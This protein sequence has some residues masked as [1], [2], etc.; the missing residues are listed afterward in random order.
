MALSCKM[1]IHKWDACRCSKCLTKRD[2]A[3]DWNGCKCRVCDAERDAEHDWNGCT[4]LIC[5]TVRSTGHKN[6]CQCGI[7]GKDLHTWTYA[8]ECPE[9][10]IALSAREI[11]DDIERRLRVGLPPS[12]LENGIKCILRAESVGSLRR[13]LRSAAQPVRLRA[14][15]ALGRTGEALSEAPLLDALKDEDISVRGAAIRS[16]KMIGGRRSVPQLFAALN[17]SAMGI[18]F[19]AAPSLAAVLDRIQ[20]REA[21]ERLRSVLDRTFTDKYGADSAAEALGI[22]G[23]PN[24]V[25]SLIW[26]AKYA[27]ARPYQA[28]EGLLR[29]GTAEAINAIVNDLGEAMA[30]KILE[31]ILRD[32]SLSDAVRASAVTALGKLGNPGAM[33]CLE[34]AATIGPMRPELL[35]AIQAALAEAKEISA[36][37]SVGNR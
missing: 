17:D 30:Q 37:S 6:R 23:G 36:S 21:I 16:L 18:R 33:G 3:H 25:R 1:G 19:A 2:A 11:V 15:E 27:S 24:A 29:I 8:Y 13:L 34:R 35:S 5:G 20:D 22:V 7:C 31:E 10:G 12:V 26:I 14:A 28:I 32:S 9:C 4:C